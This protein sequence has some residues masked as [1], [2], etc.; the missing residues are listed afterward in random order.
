M[1]NKNSNLE[2]VSYLIGI[3]GFILAFPDLISRGINAINKPGITTYASILAFI[4]V[5]IIYLYLL[6]SEKNN[7]VNRKITLYIFLSIYPVLLLWIGYMMGFYSQQAEKFYAYKF[8]ILKEY[9]FEKGDGLN[10]I[11]LSDVGKKRHPEQII[12][13]NDNLRFV[14]SGDYSLK[15]NCEFIGTNSSRDFTDIKINNVGVNNYQF[16][17]AYIFVESESRLT[18]DS[19]YTFIYYQQL[20]TNGSTNAVFGIITKIIPGRWNKVI[21]G[22]VDKLYS[23]DNRITINGSIEWLYIRIYSTIKFTGSIYIDDVQIMG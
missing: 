12:L 9:D 8:S 13:L 22:R 16:I 20:N 21:L 14:H 17:Q 10:S 23:S 15:T 6:F 1:K 4:I 18:E 2:N 11:S 3:I 5:I 19:L 7:R